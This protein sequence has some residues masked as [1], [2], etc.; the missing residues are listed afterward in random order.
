MKNLLLALITSALLLGIPASAQYQAPAST[1]A[2]TK[3]VEPDE[4]KLT[5]H[6]HYANKAGQTVHS[7]SKTVDNKIPQG[8]SAKCGDGT[9]SFSK[10]RRGT[11]SHHGGVATWL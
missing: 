1:Q 4:N 3:Q 11:C 7:P 6:G 8:A 10:S 2:Q 5:T 9:F